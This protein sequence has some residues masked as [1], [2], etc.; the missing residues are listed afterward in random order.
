MIEELEEQTFEEEDIEFFEFKQLNKNA[1]RV[2]LSEDVVDEKTPSYYSLLA[3]S[4]IY[5]LFVVATTK[6]FIYASSQDLRAKFETSGANSKERLT[7]QTHVDISEGRVI[8]LRFSSDQLTLIVGI[9]G[10]HIL[11]YDVTQFASKSSEIKPYQ[12]MAFDDEIKDLKPNPEK[13][14]IVAV[15]L[16]SGRVYIKDFLKNAEIGTIQSNKMGDQTTAICWSPKGKQLVCGSQTGK[17]MQYTPEGAPKVTIEPPPELQQ[18]AY[19]VQNVLWLEN[20]LFLVAYFPVIQEEH[21][22]HEVYVVSREVGVKTIYYKCPFI[23]SPSDRE[24]SPYL[25]ME[26]IKD[27]GSNLKTLVF[28]ASANSADVNL[29]ARDGSNNWASWI[30]AETDRAALPLSDVHDQDTLPVGFAL[31]FTSTAHWTTRVDAEENVQIPPV[32]I[33]YILNDESDILG[34]HCFHKDVFTSKE[35][36]S[37]M[38]APRVLPTSGHSLE[39]QP[40]KINTPPRTDA[41]DTPLPHAYNKPDTP[42]PRA[43]NKPDIPF[44]SS[45]KKDSI[46]PPIP[47]V[48][49]EKNAINNKFPFSSTIDFPFQ[50]PAKSIT[51]VP[52]QNKITPLPN[53]EAF[54][55]SSQIQAQGVSAPPSV[56]PQKQVVDQRQT[57]NNLE[58]KNPHDV[59]YNNTN[60]SI[61]ELQKIIKA[62]ESKYTSKYLTRSNERDLNNIN[63]WSLGDLSAITSETKKLENEA[64]YNVQALNYLQR[65][66]S[67]LLHEV[68]QDVTKMKKEIE[69]LMG[70]PSSMITVGHRGMLQT[71]I[72]E[73]LVSTFKSVKESV[74]EVE[75]QLNALHEQIQEKK[76]KNTLRQSPLEYIDRSIYNISKSLY[77]NA[78]QV[79]N[80]SAQLDKLSLH[81]ITESESYTNEPSYVSTQITEEVKSIMSPTRNISYSV[82]AAKST[83]AY[84][85][86]E[87]FCEKLKSLNRLKRKSPIKTNIFEE[88]TFEI[89]ERK[90]NHP[91]MISP[92]KSPSPVKV[93]N[94]QTQSHESKIISA[95]DALTS[96]TKASSPLRNVLS[97]SDSDNNIQS[98]SFDH[99]GDNSPLRGTNRTFGVPFFKVEDVVLSPTLGRQELGIRNNELDYENELDETEHYEPPKGVL[100][101]IPNVSIFEDNMNRR[102]NFDILD[103]GPTEIQDLTSATQTYSSNKSLEP[104][105][106]DQASAAEDRDD[107]SIK[108]EFDQIVDTDVSGISK[109]SEG[110]ELSSTITVPSDNVAEE[111]SDSSESEVVSPQPVGSH[112]HPTLETVQDDSSTQDISQDSVD[113]K[114]NKIVATDTSRLSRISELDQ[115]YDRVE[116]ESNTSVVQSE[117]ELYSAPDISEESATIEQGTNSNDENVET[118]SE[119][120]DEIETSSQIEIDKSAS[121]EGVMNLNTEATELNEITE[122]FSL[123]LGQSSSPVNLPNQT[124]GFGTFGD[125]SSLPNKPSFAFGTPSPSPSPFG[126]GSTFD[127]NNNTSIPPAFATPPTNVNAF[128]SLP[129]DDLQPSSAFAQPSFGQP[130]T[131]NAFGQ[132]TFGQT[133]FGQA[134]APSFGQPAFGQTGFGQRPVFGAAS[135]LGSTTLKPSGGGFAR[136]ANNSAFGGTGFDGSENASTSTA[137]TVNPSF[138]QYRG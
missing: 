118:V 124:G 134:Q 111:L 51:P 91:I 128:G 120:K 77:R 107:N 37:G 85:N 53:R 108:H 137:N 99:V 40:P 46:I 50:L 43:Y 21:S 89:G 45:V 69:H 19:Y 126:A 29:I 115:H 33:L 49:E 88:K 26:V 47:I 92:K 104:L 65:Q 84:L 44:A 59:Q 101:S 64:D 36:F 25:F 87:R 58:S 86:K 121:D 102:S 32:P 27:W 72:K 67:D 112:Q 68:S 81:A 57:Q 119:I 31:D 56:V 129:S 127:I 98:K 62:M 123:G 80:L 94:M 103:S 52:T 93:H 61:N 117:K 17:L 24:K 16:T 10:G 39:L 74:K 106:I 34:Y 11:F 14:S 42:L 105:D 13:I 20:T 18:P 1:L 15:L 109:I 60:N 55:I 70:T 3:I 66:T 76:N 136:F 82:D 9:E 122:N 125:Y 79:D 75:K 35:N 4:N 54:K 95:Q 63:T 8:C 113:L 97:F 96:F 30:P 7:Q 83:A 135:A 90:Q 110:F 2:Q 28:C 100:P 48:N 6:G 12:R 73:K 23:C 71:R 114:F 5:G 133:G 138:T 38:S 131:P 41:S 130:A 78:S 132:P 116:E 22:E